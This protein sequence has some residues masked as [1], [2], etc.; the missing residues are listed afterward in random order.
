MN[1]TI[2]NQ[3]KTKKIFSGNIGQ[4]FNSLRTLD[5]VINFC[6]HF[7]LEDF[8]KFLS[9]S[10]E[11]LGNKSKGLVGVRAENGIFLIRSIYGSHLSV[12]SKEDF[13]YSEDIKIKASSIIGEIRKNGFREY[14]IKDAVLC[15]LISSK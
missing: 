9:Y 13:N 8:V 1:R 2:S 3:Q 10:G 6:K 11:S 7:E 4:D 15:C 5:D 14:S 12:L